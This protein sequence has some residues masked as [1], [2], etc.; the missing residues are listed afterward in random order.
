MS[1][2]EHSQLVMAR[3]TFVLTL[4]LS[5][6][7]AFWPRPGWAQVPTIA[8]API[9]VNQTE[10]V[11]VRVWPVAGRVTAPDGEPVS[12][13]EILVDIGTPGH[14][15]QSLHTNLKGEYRTEFRLDAKTS[16]ELA[17]KVMALKEGYSTAQDFA[18]FKA[19]QE[20]REINLV[21]RE[22]SLDSDLPS[23]PALMEGLAARF[24]EPG[25]GG[26]VAAAK[27]D[28]AR[29]VERL[30]DNHDSPGALVPLRSAVNREPECF[31]C[32]TLLSLALL[33]TGGWDIASQYLTDGAKLA[34]SQEAGSGRAEAFLI[35][36]VVEMWRQD[37]PRA[38]GFFLQALEF[39]PSDPLVLQETGRALLL[40]RNWGAA[41]RYLEKAVGAGAS[42]E[43]RLLRIRALL[44]VGDNAEAETEMKAYIGGRR[45]MDLP[46][47]GRMV[48]ARLKERLE[49]LSYDR[50]R[51]VVERSPEDLIRSMPELEG[52][53]PLPNQKDLASVLARVQRNVETFFQQMPNTVSLE[54]IH[55]QSLN[56]NGEVQD[57]LD[58]KFQ[59]LLLARKEGRDFGLREYRTTSETGGVKPG[60]LK[61]GYMRTSG[62]ACTSL[63]LHPAYQG[64]VSF[65][66][67][68]RQAIDG[69]R[70]WVVAFAQRPENALVLER[71]DAGGKSSPVL[72]Q[73]VAWID[74]RSY[75][76]LRMRTDL[77]K[78]PPN[79]RL[80]TQTTVINYGVVRFKEV[81]STLWLP[82]EVTVT[83]EWKGRTFRNRH[84]YSNFRLFNV[85]TEEK[86]KSARQPSAHSGDLN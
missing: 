62:F 82:T 20:V 77:L 13:V 58:S 49:I 74:P 51:S 40:Q 17:V 36:G 26:P 76:I 72:I 80:S 34:A 4:A 78:S 24:R 54:E 30:L 28:Y 18:E 59:Y 38:L 73:G 23:F 67:L 35:R 39:Q 37:L 69:Q 86:R 83:V 61:V 68:G 55:E 81:A 9:S 27:E 5:L 22:D 57:F 48:Y 15:P 42:L 63:H 53:E 12:G 84:R 10:L 6:L 56:R 16:S 29:G 66:L 64:K 19:D 33:D 52:L 11:K 71:F 44:E 85:E 65:R 25:R 46:R 1:R 50:V 60:V 8:H 41:E 70:S 43:A 75:Q 14:P 21:L 47:Q 79:T 7:S 32:R 31:A 45:P 3:S 2:G